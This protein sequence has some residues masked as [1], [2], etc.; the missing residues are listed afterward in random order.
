MYLAGVSVRRVED[1]TQA[2]WGT[3][4]S[5]STISELNQKIYKQIDEWRN[6]PLK[7]N[8]PY[9]YLDGMWFKRSWGGEVKNVSL[10]IAI[11]VN[12]DGYRD[13]IGCCEG[14]KEDQKSWKSFLR[15]LKKRGLKGTQLFVSDKCLGLVE[16]LGEVFPESAWQ[17]CM[18]HFYRN[19][20]TKVPPKKVREVAA[21]LK[22]IHAQESEEAAY[23]KAK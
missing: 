6:R 5:P 3:R 22:A 1:I 9:V 12:E 21:M 8:Y 15:E 17:R 19:I 10:L 2:L 7:G 18:V 16:A 13:V 20:F 23:Q 14:A 4:V 11:G